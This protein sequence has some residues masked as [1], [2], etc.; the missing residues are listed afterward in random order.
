MCPITTT[1]QF[2]NNKRVDLQYLLQYNN[3]IHSLQ[4]DPHYF[5]PDDYQLLKNLSLCLCSYEYFEN[6][7]QLDRT[8]NTLV[9]KTIS[10]KT[11][12][13]ELIEN[14]SLKAYVVDS[15]KRYNSLMDIIHI[16]PL[17]ANLNKQNLQGPNQTIIENFL[18]ITDSITKSILLK[19]MIYQYHLHIIFGINKKIFLNIKLILIYFRKLCV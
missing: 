12:I 2:N 8:F 3:C 15:L 16:S 13:E 19:K 6:S 11:L 4:I 14:H 9:D 7:T 17:C 18:E 5:D 1:N 10:E